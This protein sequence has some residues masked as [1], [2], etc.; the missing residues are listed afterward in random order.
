M[1]NTSPTLFFI[2]MTLIPS[3][4][5]SD[6]VQTLDAVAFAQMR[7]STD[8]RRYLSSSTFGLHESIIT[9]HAALQIDS[10][11]SKK[12]NPLMAKY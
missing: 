11:V 7:F 5:A 10:N 8:L 9:A 1:K 3:I 2:S 12:K 4:L 6:Y